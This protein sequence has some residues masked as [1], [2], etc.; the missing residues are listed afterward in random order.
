[1]YQTRTAQFIEFFYNAD[2]NNDIVFDVTAIV[3]VTNQTPQQ[4]RK[5]EARYLQEDSIVVTYTTKLTFK[6]SD[7]ESDPQELVVAPFE[8]EFLRGI[9][10]YQFLKEDGEFADVTGVTSVA[11]PN[12]TESPTQMPTFA[13]TNDLGGETDLVFET[14][15]HLALVQDFFDITSIDIADMEEVTLKYLL[16]NIGG[17]NKFTPEELTIINFSFGIQTSSVGSGVQVETVAFQMNVTLSMKKSFADW[18]DEEGTIDDSSRRLAVLSHPTQRRMQSKK[19]SPKNYA[20]CCLNGSINQDADSKT[21]K[22][23]GCNRQRCRKKPPKGIRLLF[24]E[25]DERIIE[26]QVQARNLEIDD[27]LWGLD[28]NEVLRQYTNFES[29]TTKS[30]LNATDTQSVATCGAERYA[31]FTNSSAFACDVFVINNCG[32][33]E[34]IEFEE[35]EEL[36]SS[37]APSTIPST[38]PSSAPS[39]KTPSLSPTISPTYGLTESTPPTTTSTPTETSFAPSMAPNL[40]TYPPTESPLYTPIPT[41][42]ITQENEPSLEPTQFSSKIPTIDPSYELFP[43]FSP[44]S[45]KE[46]T[47]KAIYENR[48]E[49]P[50]AE[51]ESFFGSSVSIWNRLAVIGAPWAIGE[52][53]GMTGSV[54]VYSQNYL[55]GDDSDPRNFSW[56][57]I[58]TLSPSIIGGSEAG[59]SVSIV[60]KYLVVGAPYDS[61]GL[62]S[63]A[64]VVY[65]YETVSF[66]LLQRLV[67]PNPLQDELFGWSV[68]IN[69][70]GVI[71]IGARGRGKVY[72]FNKDDEDA[73]W[74]LMD[75]FEQIDEVNN[76]GWSIGLTADHLVVGAPDYN[77]E[78]LGS[79]F[80]YEVL[81]D[82]EDVSLLDEIQPV[83]GFYGDGFGSSVDIDGTTVVVG[84]WGA[85]AT[86]IYNITEDRTVFVQKLVGE[87]E[88]E[89]FGRS[90]S[91]SKSKLVVRSP[92]SETFGL[93]YLYYYDYDS[94]IWKLSQVLKGNNGGALAGD[95]GATVA[96]DGDS[97]LVGQPNDDTI[98]FSGEVIF[99]DIVYCLDE[100]TS[101]PTLQPSA[102]LAPSVTISPTHHLMEPTELPTTSPNVAPPTSSQPT[103]SVSP[104][105]SPMSPQTGTPSLSPS[106]SPTSPTVK[107]TI[108]NDPTSSPNVTPPTTDEP[109][110]SASPTQSPMSLQNNSPSLSPSTSPTSPTVQPTLSN[111]P[112]S[113]DSPTDSPTPCDEV[114]KA[115]LL[116]RTESADGGSFL[117]FG[118]AVSIL[119]GTALI[120][121]PGTH[122]LYSGAAYSYDFVFDEENRTWEYAQKLTPSPD[123]EVGTS[124]SSAKNFAVIGGYLSNVSSTEQAGAAWIYK[125]GDDVDDDDLRL[126]QTLQSSNP[127]P[128]AL[129]GW[130]AA[131]N[132]IGQVAI[133]A[134]AD[135]IARGSV[136]LYDRIVNG[137]DVVWE[138]D[139]V[140]EP[141]VTQD[142]IN[143]GNFGWSVALSTEVL[144]VGAPNEGAGSDKIGA[145]FVY[146]KDGVGDWVFN[147]KIVPSDG[148]QGDLFGFSVDI[149]GS[150]VVVGSREAERDGVEKSGSI[151]VYDVSESTATLIDQIWPANN[152]AGALYGHSVSITDGLIAVG[153][154]NPEAAGSVFLYFR[155]QEGVWRYSE[156]LL[157]IDSGT[158]S[159]VGIQFGYSVAVEGDQ[160]IVGSP[161]NDVG[162]ENSGSVFFYAIEQSP[163]C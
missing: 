101:N 93:V 84:S 161:E 34:D 162:G 45:C 44:T 114:P 39:T 133:G 95:Y 116:S 40:I 66:T 156:T 14:S 3:T 23:L 20:T 105:Q 74:T 6:T 138:L 163:L 37:S 153:S 31:E 17:E 56:E 5:L 28:F 155:D 90:V 99:Y 38:S 149:H 152:T 126:V 1:L 43:S 13:P 54:Y 146:K 42:F 106:A 148:N 135:R 68:A 158:E 32:E 129:F 79:V 11:L 160:L 98:M 112:T 141:D 9:Y 65:V 58:E 62:P 113:E 88:D 107:P 59:K 26:S 29:E 75:A 92:V 85:N 70:A 60:G 94:K 50:D 122:T 118:R 21:C 110:S 83:D 64:G 2:V 12:P 52:T 134:R 142:F 157:P 119:N 117:E 69:T 36:C 100:S 140:L 147:E 89:R 57:Y 80:L 143:V 108:S 91:I 159:D 24:E 27:N 78:N 150:T 61:D 67:S 72:I 96:I 145:V 15:F 49:G 53:A 19:C 102:S 71:A 120:G 130:S 136:Y 144:V 123:G 41:P 76:F 30:I 151:Y 121:A 132:E 4:T 81:V 86:Y 8:T 35:E 77:G 48:T 104:T 124:V 46:N 18:V 10:V 131:V 63:D 22:S 115:I 7:P 128:S 33:N 97:M 82:K 55:G 103:S 139:V 25:L 47:P 16:D 87:I 127:A 109:T 51:P 154:P 73:V 111:S 125:R 137:S